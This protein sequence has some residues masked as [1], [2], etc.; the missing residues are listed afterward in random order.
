MRIS[1]NEVLNAFPVPIYLEDG[2]KPVK[3]QIK[4]DVKGYCFYL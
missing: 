4:K 1:E 3:F 2:K